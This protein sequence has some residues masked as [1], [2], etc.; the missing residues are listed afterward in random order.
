MPLRIHIM[1]KLIRHYKAF[2]PA[3]KSAL[4]ILF[5][6]PGIKAVIIHRLSH[7]LYRKKRYFLARMVSEFGRSFTGIELHPGAKIAETV[8]LEHGMGTVIGETV[9][10]GEGTVI[11]HGVTLGARRISDFIVGK[12]HPTVGKNV[13]IG[14]GVKVLGAVKIGDGAWIG[15]NSVVLEDVPPYSSVAGIPAKIV[16]RRN[17]LKIVPQSN[18][19]S[20]NQINNQEVEAA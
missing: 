6:Y 10:I 12:R 11:L 1:V 17:G 4:E 14:A 13:M 15:A 5:L 16:S 8:I 19:Q 20:N 9:E 18:N 7:W 2:D 3:A